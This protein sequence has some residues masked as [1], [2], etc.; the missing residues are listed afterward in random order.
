[1]V[2][3][4]A[5]KLYPFLRQKKIEGLDDETVREIKKNTS[6][7]I[8]HKVGEIVTNS[9]DNI[10][11][12]VMVG[13][14]WVGLYSN[15]VLITVALNGIMGQF[16]SAI[17]ASIGNLG[18]TSNKERLLV[19]FRRVQFATFWIFGFS[20]ICLFYLFNPFI[21]VWIGKT[22]WLTMDTEQVIAS[23]NRRTFMI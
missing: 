17:T 16:F 21:A 23:V 7:M 13:T 11:I 22:Y 14:I 6:A 1:M 9:T 19:V 15:Y 8:S 20:A 18:A 5:D 4:T 12:S 2:A 10:V 3:R